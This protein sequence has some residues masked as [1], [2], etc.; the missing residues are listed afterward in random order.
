VT[1][2]LII[3]DEIFFL[4]KS[5]FNSFADDF[6]LGDDVAK[7][8]LFFLRD[9]FLTSKTS[10]GSALLIVTKSVLLFKTVISL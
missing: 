8:N 5:F 1:F 7:T 6:L 3:F 9:V 2:P 10:R 4:F